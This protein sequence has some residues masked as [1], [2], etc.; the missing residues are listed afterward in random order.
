M[1]SLHLAAESPAHVA[2][3]QPRP[4]SDPVPPPERPIFPALDGL[5]GVAILL[6]LMTHLWSY[7]TGHPTLNLLAAIGWSGVDLFFVLSGFLIT[8]ILW[9]TRQQPRYWRNFLGRRAL[10]IFPLYYLL[11]VFVFVVLPLGRTSPELLRAREDWWLYAAYLGNVALALSGWQLFMLD[12]TWSLSVEEQFYLV[13]PWVVRKL[14]APALILL[15]VALLVLTPALRLVARHAFD[16]NGRWLLMIP[17]FRADAFATGALL[18]LLRRVP[19]VSPARV[20]QIALGVLGVLGPFV[21]MRVVRG[22]F[23]RNTPFVDTLGFSVMALVMGAAVALAIEPGRIGRLLLTNRLMRFVGRVSYGLYLVHPVA[24]MIGGTLM[25][26]VFG[27][28]ID[29]GAGLGLA[30]AQLVVVSLVALA[31]AA[32]SF[33]YIETP[34]LSLKRYFAPEREATVPEVKAA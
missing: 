7:P 16:L 4:T 30:V 34:I 12:I 23:L 26:R 13:W 22:E 3:R 17:V 21:T 24:L 1:S 10:R 18:A 5:R 6:V 33:R 19:L 20:R 27:Q 15:C 28:P 32:I 29:A 25:A 2:L 9:D 11:L 14:T 31:A 8:G